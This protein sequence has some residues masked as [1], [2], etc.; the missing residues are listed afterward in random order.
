[1]KKAGLIF[2][3]WFIFYPITIPIMLIYAI[4]TAAVFFLWERIEEKRAKGFDSRGA[5]ALRKYGRIMA[6]PLYFLATVDN[7]LNIS[8]KNLK[9]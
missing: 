8:G 4:P 5:K 6:R 2:V 9:L 7:A 1:M 3:R